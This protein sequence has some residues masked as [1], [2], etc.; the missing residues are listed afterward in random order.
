M[1]KRER[2]KRRRTRRRRLESREKR[3]AQ[4]IKPILES[5]LKTEW[6]HTEVQDYIM[7]MFLI[8]LHLLLDVAKAKMESLF[9]PIKMNPKA[10]ETLPL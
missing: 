1:E 4:V 9:Q 2:R 3:M 7:T 5:K 6:L 8:K 10:R